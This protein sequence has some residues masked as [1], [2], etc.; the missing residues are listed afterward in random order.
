MLVMTTFLTNDT[1]IISLTFEVKSG[2]D[3]EANFD[4]QK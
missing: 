1:L 3:N 2:E 4:L